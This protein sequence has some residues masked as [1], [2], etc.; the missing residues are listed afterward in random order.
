MD[1]STTAAASIVGHTTI[2]NPSWT[3]I[4]TGAWGE[5]TGVI[6]NVFTPWTYDRFPTVF[7]QLEALDFGYRHHGHRRL[8]RH[9]RHRRRRLGPVPTTTS[10]SRRSR[11]TRTGWRPMT[12]SETRRRRRSRA[13]TRRP[14]LHL[15][16]LRRGRRERAH[17]RRRVAGVRGRHQQRR[18][19]P[20]QDHGA[21]TLRETTRAKS[22]PS[23][24]SPTTVTSRRRASVTASNHPMRHRHSSSPTARISRTATSTGSTR[25]S[26]SRRR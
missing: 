6:N 12:R 3:A 10:T 4:L 13:P 20:R 18:Q 25:S 2:S 22:G 14:E 15:Q 9:H 5:R 7:N 16:L 23:S 1:T 17:V 11:A 19:E 26:T 8:G 24:W 21:V